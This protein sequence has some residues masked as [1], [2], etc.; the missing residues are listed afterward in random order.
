MSDKFSSAASLLGLA[1]NLIDW[2]EISYCFDAF[3]FIHRHRTCVTM[4]QWD[5]QNIHP[6]T[7]NRK[8]VCAFM[9]ECSQEHGRLAGVRN[10]L[11]VNRPKLHLLII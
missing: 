7:A 3:K 10:P 8:K 2:E 6:T 5:L 9:A 1:Q 4:A 11:E